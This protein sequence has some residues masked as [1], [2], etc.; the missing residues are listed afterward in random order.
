VA[1]L[2]EKTT[3]FMSDLKGKI[4]WQGGGKAGQSE[5][6]RTRNMSENGGK[7]K[8]GLHTEMGGR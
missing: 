4:F 5:S 2:S 1:L 8:K 7:P 3:L 6:L